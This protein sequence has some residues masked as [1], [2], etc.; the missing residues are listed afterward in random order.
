MRAFAAPFRGD[1]PNASVVLGV[2]LVGRDL[3]L[4]EQARLEISYVVVDGRGRTHSEQHDRMTPN[5]RPE[6]RAR[7][8]DTGLRFLNRLDLR[9]GRYQ[10]R[11]AA[12]D[13]GRDVSGS[14]IYDLDVPHFDDLPLSISGVVLTSMSG[15]ALLTVR[16]DDELRDLLPAPPIAIRDF[17]QNDE[18]AVFA[19]VYDNTAPGPHRVDIVTTIRSDEG[20]IYFTETEQR[21]SSRPDADG[22]YK[23]TAR[24][25]LASI[26]PGQYVLS[27]DARSRTGHEEPAVR[28][29]RF[30]VVPPTR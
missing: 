20:A 21:E 27:I 2:E 8:Q 12:H 4:V 1:A 10:V 25:P 29:I 23:Y 18:I 16:A 7:V 28:H 3:S 6:N 24:I 19:E 22:A 13:H 26:P 9:P 11:V 17:P 15:S 5:L 14:V 30:R